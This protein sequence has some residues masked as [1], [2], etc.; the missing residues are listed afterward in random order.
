M[1]KIKR[2]NDADVEIGGRVKSR[3][4]ELGRSQ[5]WL[6]NKIGLTFQQVQKYEKGSNRIGGSRMQQ[7]AAALEVQP[8]YFFQAMTDAA[9]IDKSAGGDLRAFATSREGLAIISMWASVKPAGRHAVLS[10]V[11]SLAT[12]G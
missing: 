5:E 2:T 8:G 11:K 3:R 6:A 9:G 1:E 12:A 10:V 4:L 7:I